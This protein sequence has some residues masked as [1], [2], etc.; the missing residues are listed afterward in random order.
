V[1]Q[2]HSGLYINNDT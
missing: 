2:I 1:V